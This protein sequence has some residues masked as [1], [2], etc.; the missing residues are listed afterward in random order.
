MNDIIID[1]KSLRFDTP[2]QVINMG[3]LWIGELQID[4]RIRIDSVIADNIYFSSNAKKLYFVKY[5]QVSKWQKDNF[6]YVYRLDWASD[7]LYTIE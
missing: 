3:G 4:D 6:F 5:D 2:G 7:D 1:G